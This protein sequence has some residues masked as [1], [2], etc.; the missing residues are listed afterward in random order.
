MADPTYADPVQ[1]Q[2]SV[3]QNAQ[4]SNSIAL[5]QDYDPEVNPKYDWATKAVQAGAIRD[6]LTNQSIMN[7]AQNQANQALQDAQN[8]QNQGGGG[9][10]NATGTGQY[11][12]RSDRFNAF[13]RAIR[14]KE[15]GGNYSAIN[16][17]A[18]G[19]P[20]MGAYQI[21]L[22][23]IAG[24]NTGW[25]WEAIKQNLNQQDFMKSKPIQD[26]IAR[27]KLRQFFDQY[28]LRGAASA[29]YSGSPT[30]WND[31]VSGN[32]PQGAY[33]T[34]HEYVMDILHLMGIR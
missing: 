32:A 14:Q 29:W 23:N 7:Q 4:N 31:S 19:G 10:G 27:Y 3:F 20:A 16:Y 30:K 8:Q 13:V 34:I 28:G 21:L 2:A 17:D 15:S 26:Q 1:R 12:N 5:N 18:N 22:D 11:H 6:Q 9:G 33:P 25:D 24:N